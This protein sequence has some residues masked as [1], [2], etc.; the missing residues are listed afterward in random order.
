MLTKEAQERIKK[1]NAEIKKLEQRPA[2]Q[3]ALKQQK[4]EDSKKS[5]I[6]TEI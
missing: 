1:L 2:V 6:I 4:K 3:E 5:P